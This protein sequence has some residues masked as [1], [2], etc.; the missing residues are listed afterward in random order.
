M[1]VS[2][3]LSA[4]SLRM[5][6]ALQDKAEE[7]Q[8]AGVEGKRA[9]GACSMDRSREPCCHGVHG[10]RGT[11]NCTAAGSSWQI[12]VKLGTLSPT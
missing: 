3:M 7:D 9:G 4:D 1:L 5:L 12:P 6:R 11:A 8:A 2:A 10:M